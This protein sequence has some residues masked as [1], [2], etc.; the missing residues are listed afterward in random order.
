MAH[1]LGMCAHG[2]LDVCCWNS[3]HH[4]TWTVG[5]HN[6]ASDCCLSLLVCQPTSTPSRQSQQFLSLRS[7][8]RSGP[9]MTRKDNRLARTPLPPSYLLGRLERLMKLR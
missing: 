7:G 6:L 5:Q 3:L 4:A 1:I 8:S 9:L 2:Q